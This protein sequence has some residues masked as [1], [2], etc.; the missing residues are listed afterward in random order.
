M[1]LYVERQCVQQIK[2][3]NL[4][5]FLLLFDAYFDDL[6]KYVARRV[7]DGAEVERIVRLTFLDALGQVQNTPQDTGYLVWL[8]S[9]AKPRVWD[10]MAKASFPEKQGLIASQPASSGEKGE[11][12]MMLERADNMVKKLSLEER[13]ILR[14]KFFEELSDGDVMVILGTQEAT[15]GSKIY[16]VLKRAHFLLFGESDER[17][18]V[19]FGELSAFMGR[20]REMETVVLPA[21]LKLSLRAD[22]AHRIESRDFAVEVEAEEEENVG[23]FKQPPVEIFEK[24]EHVGSDDPAKIFVQAVKDLTDQEKE[25]LRHEE[26]LMEKR[27]RFFD[28]VERFKGVLVGIPVLIFLIVAGVFLVNYLDLFEEPRIARGYPTDCNVEVAF[29]GEFSDGEM[30]SVNRGISDRICGKFDVER[31]LISRKG[32][33]VVDVRV[34]V[35]D[36]FLQYNFVKKVED[37]RIKKYFRTE[38]VFKIL[39]G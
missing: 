11:K 18:G 14:L 10:Y 39:N 36:W 38:D 21:A 9:L 12:E 23:G 8:Y 20:I 3:G 4:K 32:D 37:W 2:Q 6:Y 7:P 35:P 34:D 17:Q 31:I 25:E 27:E 33:G 16:R 26:E 13:E 1:D 24:K 28:F 29:V 19:Y 5:Q 15:I 30:R 22:L